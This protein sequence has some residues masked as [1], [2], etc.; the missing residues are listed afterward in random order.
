MRKTVLIQA[1]KNCT[2]RERE[3]KRDRRQH[4]ADG[5]KPDF[6]KLPPEPESWTAEKKKEDDAKPD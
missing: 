3:E 5:Y 6:D 4:E 2:S 1:S